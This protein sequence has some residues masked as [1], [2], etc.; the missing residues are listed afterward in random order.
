MKHFALS[1]P[2]RG[3]SCPWGRQAFLHRSEWFIS[4]NS[5]ARCII[6]FDARPGRYII[7]K[8]HPTR[9]FRSLRKAVGWAKQSLRPG[10]RLTRFFCS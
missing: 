9:S 7:D 3:S 10:S 6:R 2:Y 1:G 8:T 4:R 5:S